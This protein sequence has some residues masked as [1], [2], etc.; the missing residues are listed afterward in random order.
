MKANRFLGFLRRN[1]AKCPEKIK[2]QAYCAFVRP[3]LEYA[4][5]AWDP[6]LKKDI[7]Q[8]EVVQRRAARFVKNDYNRDS[9]TSIYSDLQWR[10]LERLYSTKY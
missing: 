1:V 5:T 10:S 8:L 2:E 9:G 4:S 6:H 3:H 7:T